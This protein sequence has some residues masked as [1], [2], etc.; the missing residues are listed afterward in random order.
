MIPQSFWM[1]LAVGLAW[2]LFVLA[3][4]KAAKPPACND[5]PTC[6]PCTESAPAQCPTCPAT[7]CPSTSETYTAQCPGG[8]NVKPDMLASLEEVTC[9]LHRRGT[10]L[11]GKFLKSNEILILVGREFD[12]ATNILTIPW[13]AQ[14]QF[15]RSERDNSWLIPRQSSSCDGQK[16]YPPMRIFYVKSMGDWDILPAERLDRFTVNFSN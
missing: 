1:L 12:Q 6:P 3:M 8:S 14:R 7:Q 13:V 5:C 15:V 2:L 4:A 16:A 11:D 10:H 9:Y